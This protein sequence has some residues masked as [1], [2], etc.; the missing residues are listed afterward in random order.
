MQGSQKLGILLKQRAML[1]LV[2]SMQMMRA[3]RRKSRF[4]IPSELFE[5]FLVLTS[6]A[7]QN[8]KEITRKCKQELDDLLSALRSDPDQKRFTDVEQGMGYLVRRTEGQLEH[9]CN[10][11]GE[12]L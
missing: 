3:E 5:M 2:L 7:S 10:K 1:Y 6:R 9:M 8:A 12:P 4:V 11:C